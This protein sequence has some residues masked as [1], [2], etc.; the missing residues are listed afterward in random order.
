MPERIQQRRTRGWR[1]PEGAIS[2]ARPS[3]WG[4]PF[5]VVD[6]TVVSNQLTLWVFST[7][8]QARA[9]AVRA[10][11]WQ[12]LNHPNVVGFTVDDVRRDLAGH[13]LMCFCPL[14]A[15]GEP[16]YCHAAVLLELASGEEH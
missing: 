4:N 5:R 16:D 10:F 9:H 12:I 15:P 7:V 11:R 14:P 1:K 3:K 2:V 6:K 13:D 8:E